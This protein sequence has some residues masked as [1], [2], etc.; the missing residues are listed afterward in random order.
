MGSLGRSCYE[1]CYEAKTLN[2]CM[3]FSTVASL[4][5]AQQ[6]FRRQREHRQLDVPSPYCSSSDCLP[7]G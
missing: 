6:N 2:Y 4:A 3:R 7:I 1:R 5:F